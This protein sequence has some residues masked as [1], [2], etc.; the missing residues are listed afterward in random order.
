MEAWAFWL[1]LLAIVILAA[2]VIKSLHRPLV[3]QQGHLWYLGN[4]RLL[5]MKDERHIEDTCPICHSSMEL[6][7]MHSYRLATNR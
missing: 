2:A 3:C 7:T 1:F 4:L 5:R 6:K